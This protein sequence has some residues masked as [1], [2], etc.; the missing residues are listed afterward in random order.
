MRFFRNFI[1]VFENGYSLMMKVKWKR[2]ANSDKSFRALLADLIKVSDCLQH[3]L[4]V[5]KLNACK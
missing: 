2:T 5:P 1:V 3:D 4:I